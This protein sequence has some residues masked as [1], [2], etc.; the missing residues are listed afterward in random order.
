ML[1]IRTIG[2]DPGTASWSFFGMNDEGDPFLDERI[3]VQ[4][5]NL[6]KMLSLI[7]NN[8]PVDAI[9]APSGYGLPVKRLDNLSME[10]Y[11]LLTL[12]EKERSYLLKDFLESLK[13]LASCCP[14][15]V[16]PG[17]KHL[18]TVAAWK[19]INRID[20]GTADKLC[21][22]VWSLHYLSLKKESNWSNLSFIHVEVG[23]GFN[24]F[25]SVHDGK[26][27]GGI[28]GSCASSGFLSG[29]FLDAE[30]AYL[31]R[32][33]LSKSTVF[34]GGA[35]VKDV[36]I[37]SELLKNN[38]DLWMAYLEGI[39]VDIARIDREDRIKTVCLSGRFI[40]DK[41]FVKI[42][43][44]E[45]QK[46]GKDV[47]LIKAGERASS[48]AKGSALLVN[49]LQGGNFRSLVDKLEIAKASGSVLD[50]IHYP[51][52]FPRKTSSFEI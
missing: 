13:N 22:T 48:A 19:K 8:L 51:V 29:G 34:T 42:L 28:G 37:P 30:V 4:P 17:V 38:P 40:E 25:I 10:D 49:G 18:P 27:S 47:W 9:G 26:I 5:D 2:I 31:L 46:V 12:K 16:L 6:D 50:Q 35:K 52:R 41:K 44:D 20:L 32:E 23:F 11:Y 43:T 3:Q 33:N 45:L 1:V 21:A 39:L 15:Y 36:A 24:A 7:K 14:C